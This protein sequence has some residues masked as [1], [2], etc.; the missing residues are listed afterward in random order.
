[1]EEEAAI[2]AV[3]KLIN[4]QKIVDALAVGR[5]EL[6]LDYKKVDP[7]DWRSVR[8]C[9]SIKPSSKEK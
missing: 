5:I 4:D 3:G 9:L 6:I 1:M 8:P 7:T 2:K